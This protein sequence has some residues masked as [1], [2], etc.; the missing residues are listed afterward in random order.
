LKEQLAGIP[1]HVRQDPLAGAALKEADSA[2]SSATMVQEKATIRVQL[3]TNTAV[4][5][6]LVLPA[7]QK[8]R[9]GA[10]RMQSANNLKQLALA[11]HNYNATHG[12]LP[13]DAIRDGASKALLSWR[14][15]ILPYIEQEELY[16]EFKLDEPWDSEHNKKLVAQMPRTYE[17]PGKKAEP[18][19]TFYCVFTGQGSLFDGQKP[20][21]LQ[22]I[23]DG[24]SNTFLAVEAAA[25]V[26]WTKPDDLPFDASKPLPKL[27][28][29]FKDG[30]NVLI[31]DG[32]VRFVSQNADEKV[33][34]LFIQPADLTPVNYSDL[35]VK[36]K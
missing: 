36:K 19:H 16:K 35:D 9:V 26:L 30:Y 31:C 32:S 34:K 11:M 25:S 2:V 27:G 1:A 28:G 13:P 18:G 23:V 14:V 21:K 5:A 17:L 10:Q 12:H 8:T 24:T 3:N 6:G 15:A 7:M 29:F 4:L 33:L 22:T 20:S